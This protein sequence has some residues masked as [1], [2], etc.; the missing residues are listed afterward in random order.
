MSQSKK[1]FFIQLLFIISIFIKT[2][3]AQYPPEDFQNPRKTMKFFLKVMKG[4]KTGDS[5][6]MPLALKAINL[7][8]IDKTTRTES[9][10]LVAEHI[11]NTIDRIERINIKKIPTKLKKSIWVYKKRSISL[12]GKDYEVEISIEKN[13]K[14]KWLFSKQ[15]VETIEYFYRSLKDQSVVKGVKELT[16]WKTP[17]KNL[18]PEWSGHQSFLILNGQWL[19]IFLILFIGLIIER[20]A[21][22]YLGK[23]TQ[24]ILNK[25]EVSTFTKT[26]QKKLT[27]PFGIMA[28]AGFWAL[29]IRLLELNDHVL[30]PC[31]RIGYIIFT[32]GAVVTAHH[33]VDV[34]ALYF[35][36]IALESDN[37][38]DD[39]LVPL[40]KKTGKFFVFAVGVI[41]IGDSLTLDMKSIL[42]GLGIGGLAFALAAKDTLSNLFGSLTVLID[43]PFRIGDWVKIGEIEG[44][45]EE[46]GLRSTR[47]RTAYDSLITLPN[48]QLTS[49]QIDNFG[50][51]R[52]RR[53]NT[54][55]GIQYD[56]P[57]EKIEAFCEGVR[58]IIINHEHTRKDYFHVYFNNMGDSALEIMLY[59]FWQV[60]DRSSELAER[61]R[62]LIDIF[63]LGNKM[64]VEFAF[65]T[66]TLHVYKEDHA[67]QKEQIPTNFHIH[68][69]ELAKTITSN[70]ISYQGPRSSTIN[71]K[72]PDGK[73]D[74]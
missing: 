25:Y 64:G 42:T 37:K 36:K 55:I 18:M 74:K 51:R 53:L 47:V 58:Q 14:G 31:L 4:H 65:P 7:E 46:V 5:N 10:S 60:P 16:S 9:G 30:S 22:Y 28:F 24:A 12:D 21:R 40:V 41:F 35:E 33:I 27:F 56:T 29:T 1:L 52:Y 8:G 54:T 43:R 34:I 72:F 66:Q 15:T 69:T 13:T 67:N 23:L 59:V 39:I 19:G 62:L 61:H 50:Q 11:I 63:R 3:E 48:G 73:I 32:V 17:I 6:A 44:A 20:V 57:A 45:V 71:G 68:G 2:T 49:I 70:P 26:H 38:F